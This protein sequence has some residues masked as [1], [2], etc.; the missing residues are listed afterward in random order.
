MFKKTFLLMVLISLCT[1]SQALNNECL[2]LEKKSLGAGVLLQ[3]IWPG[4]GNYYY[5]GSIVKP[6]IYPLLSLGTPVTAFSIVASTPDY[7]SY[8]SKR[9]TW[10]I[11]GITIPLIIQAV[12]IFDV[13]NGVKKCLI[14][15]LLGPVNLFSVCQN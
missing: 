13:K 8:D 5:S 7:H 9:T 2:L 3:L 14:S 10:T 11:I 15:P 1:Y 4:A 12:S 6:I